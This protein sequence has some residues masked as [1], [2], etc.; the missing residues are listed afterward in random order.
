M[1]T[2]RGLGMTMMNDSLIELVKKKLVEPEEAY[3]K[4]VQKTEFESLLTRHKFKLKL[5]TQEDPAE[6]QAASST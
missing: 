3:V 6:K 5:P 2:G 1:Q 4:A